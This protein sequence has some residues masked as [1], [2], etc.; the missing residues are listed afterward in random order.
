MVDVFAL[1]S[2]YGSG[3]RA[4]YVDY[5]D[6]WDIGRRNGLGSHIENNGC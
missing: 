3:Q 6:I 4:V 5:N 2:E 1:G